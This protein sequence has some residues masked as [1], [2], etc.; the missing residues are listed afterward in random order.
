MPKQKRAA[1]KK[2]GAGE[3]TVFQLE[4][5][6]WRGTISLGFVA[7][8]RVRKTLEAPTQAEV[9]GR[10]QKEKHAHG[11]GQ[12]IKPERITLGQFLDQWLTTDVEPLCAPKTHRTYS[13][14]VKLHI[15]PALGHL[16]LTKLK[17]PHVQ[18]F[19]NAKRDTL[20]AKTI[21]HLRDCLRAALNVAMSKYE[22]VPKNAAAKA[23][24]PKQVD[25]EAKS[26]SPDQAKAFLALAALHRLSALFTTVLLIGIRQA[27]ALGLS[28][29]DIDFLAKRLTVRRQLQRIKGKLQLVELRRGRKSTRTS[30]RIITLPQVCITALI[31]HRERQQ[32]ER[33]LA[34]GRWVESG[35]VFPTSIGTP[36]DARSLLRVFY[37]ILN[38]PDPADPEAD[39]KK[40]RRLLPRFRFHDLRH[41]AATLLLVQGVHP[42]TVQELLGH[43]RIATTMD[44]YSHVIDIVRTDAAD[45]MDQLFLPTPDP[46]AQVVAQ[47]PAVKRVNLVLSC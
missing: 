15:R 37:A 17:T 31:A 16:L 26:L 13:D 9:I 23:E 21:K 19:L 24:P 40:K 11:L 33:A 12:N 27:E 43:S 22:L 7:G 36:M 41:S 18:T 4:D 35:L 28:W 25:R 8:R 38:T 20:S 3:G 14:F 42:K 1:K 44:V 6:R 30:R 39:R 29:E 34:G 32:Q 46:V 10:L 2:R 47:V 5:G 45:K